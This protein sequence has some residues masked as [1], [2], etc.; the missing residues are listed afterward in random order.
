MYVI[1]PDIAGKM[2]VSKLFLLIKLQCLDFQSDCAKLQSKDV[3]FRCAGQF[4]P[5]V[6]ELFY[7][8]INVKALSS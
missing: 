2:T 1:L 5:K 6:I 4:S 7:K 8:W 3:R